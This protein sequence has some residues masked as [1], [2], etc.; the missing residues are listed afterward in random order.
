MV[1]P[2]GEERLE[3]ASGGAL[4]DRHAARKAMTGDTCGRAAEEGV[5]HTERLGCAA[6]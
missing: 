6:T 2:P 3:D 4:P 1:G 5:G